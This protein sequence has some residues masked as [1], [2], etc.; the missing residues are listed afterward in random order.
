MDDWEARD[1]VRR[2]RKHAGTT[3]AANATCT[4]NLLFTPMHAGTRYG[5]IVLLDSSSNV[6]TTYSKLAS[7]VSGIPSYYFGDSGDA[8]PTSAES[9]TASENR[10]V[11]KTERRQQSV[12]QAWSEAFRIASIMVDGEPTDY[13]AVWQ[14]ASTPTFAA[15]GVA[16]ARM[17]QYG[18]LSRRAALEELD[19]TPDQIKAILADFQQ[20][21][22]VDSVLQQLGVTGSAP[23]TGPVSNTGTQADQVPPPPLRPG[24]S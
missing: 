17:F 3:Y 9:L 22:A 13:Q 7:S 18:L 11:L 21:S 10:L 4:V 6:I 20:S 12:G 23:N 19:Y 2:L 14:D 16:I 5:A 8:N 24:I 15:K 1:F